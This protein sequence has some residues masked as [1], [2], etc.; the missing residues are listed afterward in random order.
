MRGPGGRGRAGVASQLL[1]WVLVALAVVVLGAQALIPLSTIPHVD[2]NAS[3]VV[4][5]VALVKG[6]D[7]YAGA[8]DGP[9]IDFMYGPVGAL[10]FLPAALAATP[11]GALLIAALLNVVLFFAPMAWL[12]LR[13]R[14]TPWAIGLAG[15]LCFGLLAALDGGLSYSAFTIHIDAPA[16]ALCATA[17]ALLLTRRP[18]EGDGR[19]ILSSACAALAVWTKQTTV[20]ITVALPLFLLAT[21][22]R[23]T[24]VRHCLWTAAFGLGLAAL[25]VAWFGYEPMVFN[26]FTL[27]QHHPWY[28]EAEG[29]GRLPA[30]LNSLRLLAIA[31]RVPALLVAL[32]AVLAA[33]GRDERTD[34][35]R[36]APWLLLLTIG[37]LNVPM[38]VLG[39]AKVGGYLNTH[40]YTT[41]FVLGA[42]TVGLTRLAARRPG[43]PATLALA[44]L[45]LV[46]MGRFVTAPLSARLVRQA[47][48]RAAAWSDNPQQQAYDFARAHPGEAYFP[49]NPLSTLLADGVL[50]HSEIGMWNRELAG[51]EPTP[52]HLRQHLPAG[53]R[54]VASRPPTGN[55]TW[56]PPANHHMPGFT[57][58]GSVPGLEGWD[59]FTRE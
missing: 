29:H 5:P 45:L 3:R 20:P 24:A 21:D 46:L 2:M 57:H 39:G 43:G 54:I 30:A 35:T 42:A 1:L 13:G 12:H 17:A 14:E 8:T 44:A 19:V 41:Y 18:R 36:A 31:N 25:F 50:F 9:V 7:I 10:A 22:G 32:V 26:M 47:W 38:C 59:V 33:R 28:G 16:L 11:S 56:L 55:L 48:A 34:W 52:A 6:Y 53:V 58:P 40:S 27:L 49:W 4:P 37:V 51:I 15:L 23:A